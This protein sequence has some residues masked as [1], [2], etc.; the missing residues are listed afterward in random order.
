MGETPQHIGNYRVVRRLG[1]GGMGVVYEV[2]HEHIARRAAI[3]VLHADISRREEFI[4]RFL[5]EARAVNL[6]RHPGLVEI[7]DFG[8][9]P[10]GT[11][12]LVMEYLQGES[13]AVRMKRSGRA[14]ATAAVPVAQQI[15]RAMA[16]AHAQHIFHRDLKPDNVMLVTDPERPDLERVK[17]LDFGIAK[18]VGPQAGPVGAP[19]TAQ[20]E[21]GTVIGTPRYMS[22]EQ[23]QGTAEVDGKTDV[24][25]LGIMLYEMLAGEG[26][27]VAEHSFDMMAMQV[28]ASPRPLRQLAPSV[29][30]ELARLVHEMLAKAPEERPDMLQVATA[31]E[32]FMVMPGSPPATARSPHRRPTPAILVAAVGI[33][34]ALTLAT[35]VLSRQP[36][37]GSAATNPNDGPMTRRSPARPPDL[38]VDMPRPSA[39]VPL[40][41]TG[42]SHPRSIAPAAPSAMKPGPPAGKPLKKPKDDDDVDPF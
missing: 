17:I 40:P 5:N 3:K 13:L 1:A 29:D 6:A 38:V 33:A 16:A 20:T 8:L 18:M 30:E 21:P 14:P 39:A 25:A 23:C 28:R 34:M 36:P 35:I 26:P 32:R 12:F 42:S 11:P 31:L 15:A 19:A 9:L 41:M 27:F 2:V 22:P 10:G 7:Y 37:P 24:Y 4:T